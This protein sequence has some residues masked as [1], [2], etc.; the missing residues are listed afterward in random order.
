MGKARTVKWK[1]TIPGV[2]GLQADKA[3]VRVGANDS[4]DASP[5]W[6][7]ECAD[8]LSH[9]TKAQQGNNVRYKEAC[10]LNQFLTILNRL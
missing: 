4:R 3:W 6:R 5:Q 1:M 8:R 9:A 2:G 7:R 10:F